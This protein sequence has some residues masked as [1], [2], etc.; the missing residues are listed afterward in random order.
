MN[1]LNG[2]NYWSSLKKKD[3]MQTFIKVTEFLFKILP[4]MKYYEDVKKILPF[5]IAWMD[6]ENIML[7]DISQSEKD[8][9]CM[10]SLICG[11]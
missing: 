6:L 5:A 2:R 1:F 8:K 7:S 11:I 3:I 10:I 4:I 9:Y